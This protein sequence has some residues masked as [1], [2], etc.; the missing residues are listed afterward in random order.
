MVIDITEGLQTQTQECLVLA[1]IS[2]KS[3]VIILNK[4]D[5]IDESERTQ[6]VDKMIAK[7]SKNVFSKTNLKIIGY[8]AISTRDDYFSTIYLPKIKQIIIN[9]IIKIS[10]QE[11][12]DVDVENIEGHSV[13]FCMQVDHSF[14]VKGKGNVF[15]GTV[16]SGKVSSIEIPKL[17][18][19]K[20]IKSIQIF[21][22][23]QKSIQ[24]YDRAAICIKG[25][26]INF[27]R[28]LIV[29][30]K[31]F[32]STKMII[33]SVE[34]IKYFNKDIKS[35]EK[36]HFSI[37]N[38]TCMATCTFFC[39]RSDRTCNYFNVED[40]YDYVDILPKYIVD[41]R[42]F[43]CLASLSEEITICK[44]I[45]MR[46]IYVAS[47]LDNTNNKSCRIAFH[48]I[49]I[50]SLLKFKFPNIKIMKSK[51][52]YGIMDRVADKNNCVLKNMFK[53]FSNVTDFGNNSIAIYQLDTNINKQITDTRVAVEILTKYENE[54]RYIC[55]CH[56]VSSF[57]TTGKIKVNSDD[58]VD[59][60]TDFTSL[61]LKKFTY[62]AVMKYE[63]CFIKS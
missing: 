23:N 40:K 24:K 39:S 29:T 25:L 32:H 62:M 17:C 61:N 44:D 59:S 16:L 42:R 28:G 20:P 46:W 52:K 47:K 22:K 11:K 14:H 2:K 12:N 27:E 1:N 30:P 45:G 15:T 37:G 13:P 55:T 9:Y 56:L 36:Y 6:K 50:D 3:V 34:P 41:D 63:K 5:L 49:Y 8:I 21:H 48:G 26:K 7:L 19:T 33:L 4:I 51:K 58:F 60:D 18:I 43:F 31:S 57:G 54:A 53:P 10:N 35:D 38:S